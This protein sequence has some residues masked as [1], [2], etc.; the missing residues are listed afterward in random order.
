MVGMRRL[1]TAAHLQRVIAE[2]HGCRLHG[3]IS[4]DARADEALHISCQTCDDFQHNGCSSSDP[5][6][7]GFAFSTLRSDMRT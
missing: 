7:R 2:A 1:Y 4:C 5:V 6:H 3:C